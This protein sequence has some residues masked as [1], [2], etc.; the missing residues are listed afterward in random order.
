VALVLLLR[1]AQH[2]GFGAHGTH[3]FLAEVA[4]SAPLR[5]IYSLAAGGV[6]AAVGWWA[7]ARWGRPLVAVEEAVAPESRRLPFFAT[8]IDAV[9]Q[10]V[11]AGLGSPLG[12][13][14]APRA[15][16][17][18]V[19][20]TLAVRAGLSSE[21]TRI[22]VACSAGAGLAAVYGVP[23]AGTLFTL[24]V[25]LTSFALPALMP[26]VATSGLAALVA[27]FFLGDEAQ[28]RVPTYAVGLSLCVFAIL[29]GP[30]FGLL[31]H[32]F[33]RAAT[34][35]RAFA[36]RRP[37][38]FFWC[39]PTFVVIGAFGIPFPQLL[40]NGQGP[41]QLGFDGQVGLALAA[42]L[43]LLR[44]AA[45]IVCLG[46]GA[47]GGLLTPAMA[48]GALLAVLLGAGWNHLWPGSPAGAY[49]VVGAAA[50]LSV[51]ARMPLTAIALAC[52]LTRVGHDFYVPILL[53]VASA[54]GTSLIRKR[55][56]SAPPR[57]IP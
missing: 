50:F 37:H 10:I 15:L 26:A 24:E 9:L 38:I 16:A 18:A 7:L 12:R 47:A 25:L 14:A 3:N 1:A 53:G 17:A 20:D 6:I 51:S 54:T 44:F 13:E 35:A 40:G 31:A 46:S 22:L 56:Y 49:A 4:A 39:L 57:M 8:S 28:Y 41:A 36:R 11:T 32:E 19:T 33:A 27:R 42:M 30:V 23:L 34:A 29:S 5:R 48:A 43:L 2:L 21:Q 45:P 52:E 55:K